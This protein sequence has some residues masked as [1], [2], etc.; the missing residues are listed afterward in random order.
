MRLQL[1]EA[2]RMSHLLQKACY[3]VC[4]MMHTGQEAADVRVKPV[5]QACTSDANYDPQVPASVM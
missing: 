2:Q 3:A 5:G 4:V 1:P